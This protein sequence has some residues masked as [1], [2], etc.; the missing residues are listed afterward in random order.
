MPV[1]A[2][3]M[4]HEYVVKSDHRD[5]TAKKSQ[6]TVPIPAEHETFR[7]AVI[8]GWHDADRAWGLHLV[9]GSVAKLGKRAAAYSDPADLYIAYF[10]LD[11]VCHGYPSD[12]VKR[13]SEIPPEAVR[14]NWIDISVMRPQAVRK[15]G[16][17]LP[18]KP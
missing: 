4:G 16:R 15:L 18:C 9:E 2:N 10:H 13:S 6:W 14:R 17:G 8:N 7:L 1:S 3:I 12:P 5:G 11:K